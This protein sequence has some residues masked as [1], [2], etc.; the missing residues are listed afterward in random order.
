MQHTGYILWR[1]SDGDRVQDNVRGPLI[2]NIYYNTHDI[3]AW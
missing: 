3:I 1:K 2:I